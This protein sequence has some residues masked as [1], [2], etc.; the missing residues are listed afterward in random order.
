MTRL[1]KWTLAAGVA[2]LMGTASRFVDLQTIVV[3]PVHAQE[4]G[5]QPS[6]QAGDQSCSEATLIGEYGFQRNGTANPGGP[7]TALGHIT[8]DGMGGTQGSQTISRN[9]VFSVQQLMPTYTVNID[10]TGSL[11]DATG[12][13]IGTLVIVHGGSEVLGMSLTP[14]NNVAIHFERVFDPP[15][16]APAGFGGRSH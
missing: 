12:T 2:T 6:P 7:I 14:G 10:C 13:T 4:Q 15:G 9:G 1:S 3:P 5:A 11:V 8:F 16:N